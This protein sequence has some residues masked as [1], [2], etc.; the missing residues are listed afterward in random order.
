MRRNA[1]AIVNVSSCHQVHRAGAVVHGHAGIRCNAVAALG[2]IRAERY[3]PYLHAAGPKPRPAPNDTWSSCTRSAESATRR[4]RGHH[5][6][7]GSD[8]L[9]G[10]PNWADGRTRRR[11]SAS[12]ASSR[13]A[14]IRFG[15]ADRS[16]E[17]SVQRPCPTPRRQPSR[18]GSVQGW[19]DPHPIR[20]TPLTGIYRNV[21]PIPGVPDFLEIFGSARH[22]ASGSNEGQ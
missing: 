1:G 15:A 18:G 21:G 2:S 3:D 22:T 13:C 9:T 11:A 10:H 20:T 7:T 16:A 6:A 12:P 4:G 14:Q 19:G 8:S 5:P 17:R